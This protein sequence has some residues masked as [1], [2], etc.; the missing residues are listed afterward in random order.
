MILSPRCFAMNTSVRHS[1][2]VFA[3]AA[4]VAVALLIPIMFSVLE[5]WQWLLIE[6]PYLLALIVLGFVRKNASLSLIAGLTLPTA[7][8]QALAG[9]LVIPLLGYALGWGGNAALFRQARGILLLIPV[10]ATILIMALIV[11]QSRPQGTSW[12]YASCATST[13]LYTSLAFTYAFRVEPYVRPKPEDDLQSLGLRASSAVSDVARC[14]IAY[15]DAHPDTGYPARI[16][17]LAEVEGC[18]SY[19][20][21]EIPR[22]T[23]SFE[24][25][26]QR[27]GARRD[28]FVVRAEPEG[29]QFPNFVWYFG[30][31]SGIVYGPRSEAEPESV[32]AVFGQD[33]GL[34]LSGVRWGVEKH[35]REQGSYP[36]SLDQ[37]RERGWLHDF[38]PPISPD[39]IVEP[40]YSRVVKYL[41]RISPATGKV[42]G[43]EIESR[44]RPYGPKT[45]VRSYLMGAN[46][47]LHWTTENRSATLSDELVERCETEGSF[48]C[49]KKMPA[50]AT[51]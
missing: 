39:E 11:G 44:C 51:Q 7:I 47:D 25:S 34:F 42:T 43:Y 26:S 13:I 30:D 14:A 32:R 17:K 28:A 4:L 50:R 22:Y 19:S 36:P 15:R 48:P 9:V 35:L 27:G 12:L 46:G 10:S 38:Q 49:S 8:A 6:A 40:G 21:S 18:R 33:P 41:P 3:L 1:R 5:P 45:C 24:S 23:L 37:L 31:A 2:S 20:P 29:M 16:E